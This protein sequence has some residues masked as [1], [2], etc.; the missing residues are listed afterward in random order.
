MTL[1]VDQFVNREVC[2]SQAAQPSDIVIFGLSAGLL[3]GGT[4]GPPV[5]TFLRILQVSVG[6]RWEGDLGKSP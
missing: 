6:A 5:V 4:F 1:E 3:A 2:V